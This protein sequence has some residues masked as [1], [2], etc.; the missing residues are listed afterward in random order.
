MRIE[1]DRF[2]DAEETDFSDRRAFERLP[3]PFEKLIVRTRSGEQIPAVVQ[4]VSL[5]GI[6]LHLKNKQRVNQSDEVELLFNY[7]SIP[8]IV[9]YV[10]TY[11]DGMTIAGLEWVKPLRF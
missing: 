7:A 2:T 1:L 11:R 3:P 8:A 6:G 5:G 10:E 9:K 4:N